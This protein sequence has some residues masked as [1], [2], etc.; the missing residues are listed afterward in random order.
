MTYAIQLNR[1]SFPDMELLPKKARAAIKKWLDAFDELVEISNRVGAR[2]IRLNNTADEHNQQVAEATA[3]GKPKPETEYSTLYKEQ[4][5]DMARQRQL[6]PAV[7]IL[8]DEAL[9][10]L[11][12]ARSDADLPGKIEQASLE[13][14][15]AIDNLKNAEHRYSSALALGTWWD[16]VNT[17]HGNGLRSGLAF[18]PGTRELVFGNNT[19]VPSRVWDA[20]EGDARSHTRTPRTL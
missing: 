17:D 5:T 9:E 8:H 4:Q 16:K 6:S 2:S 20:L 14:Q 7:T 18:T 1:D 11:D 12:A 3:Y 15:A 10:A 13:Y 19:I